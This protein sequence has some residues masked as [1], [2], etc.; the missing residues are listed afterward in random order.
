MIP[1]T[2]DV[3]KAPLPV[4]SLGDANVSKLPF[5]IERATGVYNQVLAAAQSGKTSLVVS[6]ANLDNAELTR[7]ALLLFLTDSA[8]TV[9]TDTDHKI[10][11]TVDWA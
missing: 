6:F 9:A 11:L 5:I 10:T 1:L 3:L 7:T 4:I 8:I 2:R